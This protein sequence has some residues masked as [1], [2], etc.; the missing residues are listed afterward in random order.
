MLRIID[1]LSKELLRDEINI[2]LEFFGLRE[3]VME[4]VPANT[5]SENK[6]LRSSTA[7]TLH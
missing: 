6:S 7:V 3:T 4:N 2:D 1:G 5:S